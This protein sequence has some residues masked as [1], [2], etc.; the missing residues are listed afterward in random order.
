MIT[1]SHKELI[2]NI[3]TD[4][5]EVTKRQK[6][7]IEAAIKIISRQGYQELTTRN[8]GIELQLSE[9]A[10]YRHFRSKNDLVHS[11]LKHFS[12]VSNSIMKSIQIEGL[13]PWDRIELFIRNRFHIF[14][15]NP[16][17]GSVIFSEELYKNDPQLKKHMREL[18]HNHKE[19]ILQYL[20]QAQSQGRISTEY[21]LDQVF[22]IVIGSMRFTVTNWVMKDFKTDLTKDGERLIHTLRTLFLKQDSK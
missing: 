17:L 7:I 10:L 1:N 19:L 9:A 20:A 5:Q 12:D 18:M 15:A 13:E 21:D 6:N 4:I 2:M 8:L 16:D 11:I 14:N 3:I 22:N